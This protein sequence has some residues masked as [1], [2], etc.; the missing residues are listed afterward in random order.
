MNDKILQMMVKRSK[1]S[2]WQDKYSDGKIRSE[3]DTMTTKLLLPMGES[4][5]SR[6]E[7]VPKDRMTNLRLLCPNGQIGE[8][9]APE[10]HRFFQLKSGR[11]NAL[12]QASQQAHIIG[13]VADLNGN[14]VCRS[15]DYRLQRL[16]EFTDNIY[17]MKYC[18]IGALSLEVQGLRV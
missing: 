6:W 4:R 15:W 12:S 7:E 1:R 14:C 2:W 13:V 3:W 18:Q 17:A 8:L 5:T 10:G 9:E 16:L 11:R